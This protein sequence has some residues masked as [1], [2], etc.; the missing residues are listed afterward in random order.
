MP[1]NLAEMYL[2]KFM[3]TKQRNRRIRKLI[4]HNEL[5]GMIQQ[6]VER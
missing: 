4:L 6:T 3:L 2:Q 1:N 5:A